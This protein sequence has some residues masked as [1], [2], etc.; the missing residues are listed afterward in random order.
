MSHADAA[1]IPRAMTW[2]I[3]KS[4]CGEIL[5]TA[6]FQGDILGYTA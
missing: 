1:R 6:Q 3:V 2:R 5:F 4:N